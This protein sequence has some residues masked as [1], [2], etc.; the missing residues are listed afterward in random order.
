MKKNFI[1]CVVAFFITVTTISAEDNLPKDVQKERLLRQLSNALVKN[2]YQRA[3]PLFDQVESLNVAL[4]SS[5]KFF[6]GET[7]YNLGEFDKASSLIKEYLKSASTESKFYETAVELLMRIDDEATGSPAK[8]AFSFKQKTEGEIVSFAKEMLHE[9]DYY[10]GSK[11]GSYSHT[12]NTAY[13]VFFST[14]GYSISK[15]KLSS[16]PNITFDDIQM[17]DKAISKKR[18]ALTHAEESNGRIRPYHG[19]YRV[20]C[21]APKGGSL[22]VNYSVFRQRSVIISSEDNAIHTTWGISNYQNTIKG[23]IIKELPSKVIEFD[24][25]VEEHEVE[26]I[27]SKYHG[28]SFYVQKAI[29]KL[30]KRR[31]SRQSFIGFKVE[32][33]EG[34]MNYHFSDNALFVTD[35]KDTNALY[36]KC[37]SL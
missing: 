20:S 24:G 12:F 4:P 29:E 27:N 5:Y 37:E 18:N 15:E 23:N 6:K 21:L 7:Y 22:V 19:V 26:E 13:N 2:D 8:S 31:K 33:G 10:F 25:K 34:A 28:D 16:K 3:L 17:I 32:D 1:I 35:G 14:L 30:K 11:D 36:E 9:L